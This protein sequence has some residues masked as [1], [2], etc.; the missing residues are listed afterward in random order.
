MSVC[1]D[2]FDG[3][4]ECS[5]DEQATFAALLEQGHIE[6][7]SMTPEPTRPTHKILSF[8]KRNAGAAHGTPEALSL[9]SRD[10]FARM[11]GEER[12]AFLKSTVAERSGCPRTLSG[13]CITLAALRAVAKKHDI[14]PYLTPHVLA[15]RVMAAKLRRMSEDFHGRWEGMNAD[16]RTQFDREL[17]KHLARIP[18]ENQETL[19]EAL[20]IDSLTAPAIRTRLFSLNV[21]TGVSGRIEPT[22]FGACLALSV[23]AYSVFT[24]SCGIS[25][26]FAAYM[27]LSSAPGALSHPGITVPTG[28]LTPIFQ[29]VAQGRR[30]GNELIDCIVFAGLAQRMERMNRFFEREGWCTSPASRAEFETDS[31]RIRQVEKDINVGR[32]ELTKAQI[33]L[34]QA[35]NALA[36]LRQT[37]SEAEAAV[38]TARK[39]RMSTESMLADAQRQAENGGDDS[40]RLAALLSGQVYEARREQMLAERQLAETR[41]K[42]ADETPFLE[43]ELTGLTRRTGALETQLH[44]L[45]GELEAIYRKRSEQLR[46]HLAFCA[47]R[48]TYGNRVVNWFIRQENPEVVAQAESALAEL[49]EG[50]FQTLRGKALFGDTECASFGEGYRIYYTYDPDQGCTDI[51]G[52]GHQDTETNDF[53]DLARPKA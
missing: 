16:Q 37:V 28:N 46:H 51:L 49:N 10:K 32:S 42:A 25:L 31:A 29:W 48:L 52:I 24:V 17:E 15:Q 44:D 1:P 20:R 14:D 33:Q 43:M 12:L 8:F 19:H 45:R 36:Q 4:S 5:S 34:R 35:S 26:P 7:N 3:L 39:K 47:P 22:E 38:K 27:F 53:W 40:A 6:R 21:S 9:Q 11:Q 50:V 18:R 41:Q 13:P 2:L 30:A 23:I